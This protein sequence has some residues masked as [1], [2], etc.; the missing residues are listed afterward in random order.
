MIS[1]RMKAALTSLKSG[2]QHCE[3]HVWRLMLLHQGE[4]QTEAVRAEA[5]EDARGEL[6]VASV[7]LVAVG[8]P[9]F[10]AWGLQGDENWRLDCS[11][12]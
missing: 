5:G 7:A 8:G 11:H 12:G 6:G 2:L 1:Q 9:A 3:W 4:P 10:S